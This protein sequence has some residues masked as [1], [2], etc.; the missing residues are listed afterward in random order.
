MF[1]SV[2]SAPNSS[3]NV[4]E[5]DFLVLPDELDEAA[6]SIIG[7]ESEDI[8][9]YIMARGINGNDGRKPSSAVRNS[10]NCGGDIQCP[11]RGN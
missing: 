5:T 9:E 1:S 8:D 11:S 7:E 6:Q 4:S 10:G 2:A 3:V